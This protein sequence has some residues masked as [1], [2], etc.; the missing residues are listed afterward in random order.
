MPSRKKKS[1]KDDD[2]ST[3]SSKSSK[4]DNL[5]K[6]LKKQFTQLKVQLEANNKS[7]ESD[8]EQSHFQFTHF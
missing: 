2:D 8:D 5:E 7:S 6:K 1:Q 3:I 4:I